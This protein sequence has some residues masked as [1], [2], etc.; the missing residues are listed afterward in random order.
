VAV[1]VATSRFVDTHMASCL[2][3]NALLTFMYFHDFIL[4]VFDKQCVC[5]CCYVMYGKQIRM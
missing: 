3:R 2:F 5:D 4:I 1:D